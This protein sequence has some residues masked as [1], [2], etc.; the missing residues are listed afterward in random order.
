MSKD[1]KRY[2]V[3]SLGNDF[4]SM[5]VN[6]VEALNDHEDRLQVLEDSGLRGALLRVSVAIGRL[7][8]DE[9]AA[10]ALEDFRRVC[11]ALGV[12]DLEAS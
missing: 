5:F 1:G 12:V 3:K 9:K 6:V 7:V 10:A 11:E 4:A 2:S 8:D